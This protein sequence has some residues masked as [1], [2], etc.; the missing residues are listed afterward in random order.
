MKIVWLNKKS[1]SLPPLARIFFGSQAKGGAVLFILAAFWIGLS[2]CSSDLQTRISG[3]LDQ[4]TQNQTI[5]ILP[6]GYEEKSQREAA[7][8]FRRTLYANLKD[9]QFNLLE[10]YLVDGL[11]KKNHLTRTD[12]FLNINPM[13][14]G[15]ILGVD[16][17]LI[18]R[19]NNVKRSYL[20]LH[21]S[22]E[23]SVSLQM[24]DTRTGEILWQAEQTESD[25]QGLGKIPTGITAA[26]VAPVYFVTNKLSLNRI[27]SK[28]VDK[29]TAIVKRP[30]AAEENETF[31][32]PV[33]A[34]AASRDIHRLEEAEQ[35]KTRWAQK[36]HETREPPAFSPASVNP[37][38]LQPVTL[39]A[40]YRPGKKKT[41]IHAEAK[42]PSLQPAE[43]HFEKTQPLTVNSGPT[44]F[45]TIQ[46]GAYKTKAFAQNMI[47]SLLDKG[48][49]AYV[50]LF[51]G[52][53]S[54][55]MYK[56]HVEKF[57]DKNEALQLARKLENQEHLDNFITTLNP[58]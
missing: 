5:A 46:V 6:V 42:K 35:V 31:E 44:L 15:E 29:L 24:I 50:T 36:I 55:P 8:L 43:Q 23:L 26:L 38:P 48:Y 17:V 47:D 22:I 21:S 19:M 3:N 53:E 40:G 41:A 54:E 51:P 57:E 45:Y 56:V 49:N 2:A 10:P 28:M 34:S 4:I 1:L 27:T 11:L 16:A 32:E 39:T 12:S 52:K 30:N 14:F 25:Y 18:S 20:V 7:R 37:F 33:I 58:G 13:H 9:S